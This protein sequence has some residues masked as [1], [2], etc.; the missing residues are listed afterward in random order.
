MGEGLGKIDLQRKQDGRGAP[1]G[2]T[3]CRCDRQHRTTSFALNDVRSSYKPA[4]LMDSAFF[5][6][7]ISDVLREKTGHLWGEIARPE[8]KGLTAV[9]Y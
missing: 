7:S 1:L 3:T 9:V 5:V 4:I 2:T 6:D 8:L